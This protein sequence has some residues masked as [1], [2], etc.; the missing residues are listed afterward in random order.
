[1]STKYSIVIELDYP[2]GDELLC[3]ELERELG[4]TIERYLDSKELRLAHLEV[5][6]GSLYGA[7]G[8]GLKA[9]GKEQS[10]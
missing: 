3:F 7:F 9:E 5:S 8:V 2:H 1:M 10:R 4:R 6:P